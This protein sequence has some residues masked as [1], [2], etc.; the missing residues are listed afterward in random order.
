MPPFLPY[1]LFRE[2]EQEHFRIPPINILISGARGSSFRAIN[3]NMNEF[4]NR[5]E[6]EKEL[7]P[8]QM[9][10]YAKGQGIQELKQKRSQA[11]VVLGHD[12]LRILEH[13]PKLKENFAYLVKGLFEGPLRTGV[14]IKEQYGDLC[15]TAILMA[16]DYYPPAEFPTPDDWSRIRVA[17][18]GKECVRE[19][20]D[21]DASELLGI[22]EAMREGLS[23]YRRVE[24]PGRF[25]RFCENQRKAARIWL[26]NER[27][28]YLYPSYRPRTKRA[29]EYPMT[30]IAGDLEGAGPLDVTQ[31]SQYLTKSEVKRILEI[32][33]RKPF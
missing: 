18:F 9:R 33:H 19:H 29:P 12:L 23:T 2:E 8:G 26:F 1:G 5:T 4:D 20:P 28:T 10:Y 3:E 30:F 27:E 31:A 16:I 11:K 21:F 32:E 14:P 6:K 24:E 22:H 13:Y 25:G 15:F 7:T 17:C